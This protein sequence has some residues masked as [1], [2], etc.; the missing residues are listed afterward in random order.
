MGSSGEEAGDEKE[1]SACSL[2]NRDSRGRRSKS[3]S[4]LNVETNKNLY[5]IERFS[6]SGI[7]VGQDGIPKCITNP[8]VG[9]GVEGKRKLMKKS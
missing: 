4:S 2:G 3:I 8:S 5:Y 7:R 6:S 9:R 1:P